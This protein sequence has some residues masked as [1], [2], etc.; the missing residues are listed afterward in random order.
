MQQPYVFRNEIF[1]DNTL[2]KLFIMQM[3]QIRVGLDH[4]G[5]EI[6]TE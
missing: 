3:A 4:G 6:D 5:E 1:Y 2:H